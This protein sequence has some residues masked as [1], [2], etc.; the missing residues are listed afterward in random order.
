MININKKKILIFSISYLPLIG[1]AELAVKE[2]TDR[3][4]REKFNIFGLPPF[5]WDMVTF[6]YSRKLPKFEQIGSI[7]IYRVGR[8][9][10]FF[11]FAAF[12]KAMSLH[13]RNKYV[14]IWS[15]MANRAGF[16]ALFFRFFHRNVKFLLTLQEGDTLDYPQKRAGIL[17][18][19]V[20]FLFRRIFTTADSVQ[21]I[22][23]CLSGW[24]RDNGFT[25]KIEIVPNGVD[26]E[27][28]KVGVE[29]SRPEELK[30]LRKKLNIKDEDRV[31]ITT[32]RLVKKN[33][34][35]DVIDALRY[36]PENVKFL[37]LGTGKEGWKLKIKARS[38]KGR[39]IFLGDILNE[40]VPRYLAISDVYAR[41]SLSEGLGTCFLEA[42]AAGVPVVAT[43]V[44][45]IL[46]F[47]KDGE[48]GLLCEVQNPK[49]IAEKIMI[50]LDNKELAQKIRTSAKEMVVRNHDWDLI[51]KKMNELFRRL[52][53]RD[54]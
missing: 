19:F 14:I 52:C 38:L 21:V 48:N 26:I 13:R 7:N 47:L 30:E 22:S 43:P 49:S 42:M 23:S 1:G 6:R 20:K 2:I 28:F 25:G 10:L 29:R 9:K 15:I 34:I 40:E 36:L 53:L 41:P 11:P 33:A 31:I 37:I 27:N 32:S 45:G 8:F 39:V 17:W 46:D 5:E 51:A 35:G 44:G 16:A 18:P 12:F 24:A 4:S 54:F 3:L 50:L